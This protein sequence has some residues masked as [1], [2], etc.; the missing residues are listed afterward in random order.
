MTAEE[1]DTRI[2]F[3]ADGM[4]KLVI[5]IPEEQTSD[6][7]EEHPQDTFVLSR[8]GRK[9]KEWTAEEALKKMQEKQKKNLQRYSKARAKTHANKVHTE[10]VQH[11][12]HSQE[13][14]PITEEK[15]LTKQQEYYRKN[16]EK[17]STRSRLRYQNMSPEEKHA[18][19]N[20]QR[21]A[22]YIKHGSLDG[23]VP[24]PFTPN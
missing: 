23:Y 24:K 12:E 2:L 15:E 4:A 8:R 10:D 17:L 21:M 5:D 18:Y 22:Q 7:T 11:P 19:L 20:K 3:I 16:R 14:A 9:R 6:T 1:S 13:V